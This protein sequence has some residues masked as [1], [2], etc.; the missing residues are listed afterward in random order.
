[1]DYKKNFTR[2]I[3]TAYKKMSLRHI[4]LGF[5]AMYVFFVLFLPIYTIGFWSWL[6]GFLIFQYYPAWYIDCV[7]ISPY[8]RAYPFPMPNEARQAGR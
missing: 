1:M 7:S 6:I 2:R 8:G 3:G 5:Q 4:C